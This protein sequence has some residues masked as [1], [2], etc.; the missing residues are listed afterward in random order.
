MIQR[1]RRSFLIGLLLFGQLGL[2]SACSSHKSSSSFS[3][4]S[5]MTVAPVTNEDASDCCHKPSQTVTETPTT[6]DFTIP[7]VE[8]LDQNGQKVRFYTDFVQGKTVVISFFF[9]SCKTICPPLTAIMSQVQ[10][11]LLHEG[12]SDIQLISISV[13]PVKDT[14][15]RLKAWSKNFSA[16]EGWVFLTG[17]K[18]TVDRLLKSLRTFTPDPQ[19]HTPMVLLGNE[20]QGVWK[21]VNGLSSA[22]IIADAV[23]ALADMPSKLNAKTKTPALN[24]S[25]IS[26]QHLKRKENESAHRYFGDVELTDQHGKTHRLYSDLMRGRVL[27][28]NSFFSTCKGVCPIMAQKI[29]EIRKTFSDRVGKDFVV[30]SISVDP[31]VDTPTRLN[32]YA[33]LLHSGE[34]WYFLTGT[35]ENVETAL[36]KFGMRVDS[37]ENHSNLF[38]IGNDVTDSWKKVFS[39]APTQELIPLIADVLNNHLPLSTTSGSITSK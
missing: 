12:R 24:R 29:K 30:L 18:I 6:S 13:D 4:D 33:N 5:A 14:P 2:V 19:D 36:Q 17:K 34:R 15:L 3:I 23:K 20:P 8:L 1:I 16:Q 31:E 28:V 22:D 39:L 7:N 10:R 26:S 9:T 11:K 32:E 21:Q 38:L 25:K 27:L 35:K 37:R